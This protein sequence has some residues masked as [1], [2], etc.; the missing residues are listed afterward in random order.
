[1]HGHGKPRRVLITG[2]D[3]FFG[4]NLVKVLTDR[5]ADGAAAVLAGLRGDA[6]GWR[7]RALV[8]DCAPLP[9]FD[10]VASET[11]LRDR[12]T[13]AGVTAIVHCAAY[14]VNYDQ[15][16]LDRAIAVNVGGTAHL[17]AAAAAAGVTRFVQIGTGH[18]YG[19]LAGPI[20]ETACPRPRGVYG[21]TKLAASL[22][23]LDRARTLGLPL[24][25][26]RAF[27]MYGPL[28]GAH[29]FVP[30]VMAS[31]RA[32]RPVSLTPGEQVR[33][34]AFVGDVAAG[35]GDLLDRLGDKFPAGE[36]FNLA[37][38]RALTLRALADAAV[39]AVGG[40]SSSLRWGD[41]PY[42]PDESMEIIAC[43][44]K[45]AT[46]GWKASTGLDEG[47]ALTAAADGLRPC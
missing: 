23:A 27:G 35:I 6:P 33:D 4:A 45:A 18:E 19:E 24:C 14:G 36:L 28:E 38:G 44:A 22:M 41:R 10:V 15:S 43:V 31:A 26:V 32:R 17:V 20:A 5:A 30:M 8:P 2:A 1:M 21:V 37:S 40:D 34:Y 3:G 13:D 11:A 42:R 29:K 9:G 25:V 47:M 46:L 7:L 12:L 39:R 16:D